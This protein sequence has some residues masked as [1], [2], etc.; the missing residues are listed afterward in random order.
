MGLSKQLFLRHYV[1]RSGITPSTCL[2]TGYVECLVEQGYRAVAVY[3][4]QISGF[5]SVTNSLPQ[6]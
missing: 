2:P 5:D 6:L 1:W 3:T 4:V